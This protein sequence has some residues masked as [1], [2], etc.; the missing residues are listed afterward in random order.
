MLYSLQGMEI[1]FEKNIQG[2]IFTR[3][4]HGDFGTKF[5]H[6]SKYFE[7][8]NFQFEILARFRKKI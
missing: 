2:P 4:E 8:L 7:N 1:E 6:S 3:F 5:S